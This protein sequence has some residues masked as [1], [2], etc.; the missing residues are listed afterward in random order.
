MTVLSGSITPQMGGAIRVP[1]DTSRVGCDQKTVSNKLREENRHDGKIPQPEVAPEEPVEE[2]QEEEPSVFNHITT[3]SVA[4][5][6]WAEYE[7]EEEVV[8]DPSEVAL[9]GLTKVKR[10]VTMSDHDLALLLDKLT[11]RQRDFARNYLSG[12]NTKDASPTTA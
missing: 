7:Q 3:A 2:T 4:E 6:P 11:D 1:I 9:E 10:K 5:C 12:S 8:T